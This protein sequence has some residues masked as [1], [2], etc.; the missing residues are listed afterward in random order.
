MEKVK[1]NSAVAIC[2]VVLG[3]MSMVFLGLFISFWATSKT[4]KTQLENTYMKNF[5]EM[6]SNIND[7]EVDLSKIVAT[8]SL[9]SQRELLGNVYESATLGVNNINLLPLSGNNLSGINR[10]LNSTGGFV[11]S[12]LLDNYKGNKISESDYVQLNDLHTKIKETQYDLNGYLRDLRYNYS[13]LDDVDFGDVDSSEFSA[14]IINTE[15]SKTE[16]PTLIYDGPFS[17]SVLNKEI[18][19]LEDREYTLEEVEEKLHQIFPGFA[20]Y[21]TGDTK[22][23]FETYNFDIKGDVVL[24]VAVTKKGGLLLTITAFGSG[25]TKKITA[26]EGLLLAEVFAKD[27]GID[28]MYNVWYQETGNVLYVNLAPIVNKV[29]HYSDLIKVKVDL[30]LGLVVG[31]EA[32]SYATNHKSR[33]FT[34]KISL[35][36]AMQKISPLLDIKERNM[37]IIPD[38]FVGEVNA[39]EFICTWKEY[40]YYIYIDTMTGNEANILRVIKTSNGNLL[41]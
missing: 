19:G 5:Y 7:I 33:I 15:S 18:V 31:W 29:I 37:C 22:G 8:T 20:I 36:D 39:Y 16:V 26:E 11:Y 10:L 13:I 30:T 4:Y 23:K 6:V 34:S 35:V 25:D 24:Y 21:Y 41:V 32:T 9:D 14:G 2:L 17:D 40:T 38:K 12:L 3:A 27:V 1:R 28:N